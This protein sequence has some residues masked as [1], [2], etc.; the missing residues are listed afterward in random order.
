MTESSPDIVKRALYELLQKGLKGVFR[1]DAVA[2]ALGEA[3]LLHPEMPSVVVDVLAL[4]DT[5]TT[6]MGGSTKEERDRCGHL[7]I[8]FCLLHNFGRGN[9]KKSLICRVERKSLT[10]GKTLLSS[11]PSDL[12]GSKARFKL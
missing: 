10:L 8:F 4:V 2:T 9:K 6:T 11:A 3:T 1:R 7:I 12:S 5:E